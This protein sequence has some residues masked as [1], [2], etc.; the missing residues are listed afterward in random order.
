MA[1]FLVETG[2]LTGA[3]GVLG[4]VLGVA[5]SLAIGSVLPW[6]L[7]LPLISSYL[8]QTTASVET[9]VTAWSIVVSFVVAALV[10]LIFG[11]YPAVVASRQDPIVALRHD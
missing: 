7:K 9:Q 6:L 5:V 10:G 4:I 8:G 1:Q 2:S 3:G 11:I